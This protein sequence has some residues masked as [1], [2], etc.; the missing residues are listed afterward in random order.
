M[1]TW[2]VL[3]SFAPAGSYEEKLLWEDRGV[4]A[5]YRYNWK[6]TGSNK[7][8]REVSEWSLTF[9]LKNNSGKKIYIKGLSVGFDRFSQGN[10]P[11]GW[12]WLQSYGPSFDAYSLNDKSSTTKTINLVH[13]Y[14]KSEPSAPWVSGT[15]RFE[16]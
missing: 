9:T 3:M 1:M 8:G 11:A 16:N 7:A 14:G 2:L 4:S 10:L 6:K 15:F 13:A 12:S 5:S